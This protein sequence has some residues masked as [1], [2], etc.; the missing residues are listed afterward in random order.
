ML[1]KITAGTIGFILFIYGIYCFLMPEAVTE[2]IGYL[3]NNNESKLEFIAMYGS[4]QIAIGLFCLIG[5]IYNAYLK[6]VLLLLALTFGLLFFTR[7]YGYFIY[8]DLGDYTQFATIFELLCVAFATASLYR[9]RK[10]Q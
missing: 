2:S 1:G 7:I 5:A 9:M 10:Q 4:V 3:F 6:P 8:Q